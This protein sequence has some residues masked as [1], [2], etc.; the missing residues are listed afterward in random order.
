MQMLS[1][2]V[3]RFPP[4]EVRVKQY[5]TIF[6]I[7]AS[8]Y[9]LIAPGIS[10]YRHSKP[11]PCSQTSKLLTSFFCLRVCWV[12][13]PGKHFLTVFWRAYSNECV[14]SGPGPTT[15]ISPTLP[16]LVTN[17][18][19][20]FPLLLPVF[21]CY[22]WNRFRPSPSE[23]ILGAPLKLHWGWCSPDMSTNN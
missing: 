11:Q 7:P 3:V 6:N 13:L 15:S 14:I 19:E 5:R 1:R 16:T 21:A 4:R 8:Q 22:Q 18:C 10:F 17:I 12:I 20:P 9:Q 2:T 23:P